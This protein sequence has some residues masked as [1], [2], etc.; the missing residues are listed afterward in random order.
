MGIG[1]QDR[2][3]IFGSFFCLVCILHAPA[4][5]AESVES[6]EQLVITGSKL[7]RIITETSESMT[8]IT[9]DDIKRYQYRN[10]SEAL[11]SVPGIH[12]STS[13][14]MG[15]QTSVFIRGSESDHVLV[16]IDGIKV[17]DPASGGVFEFS[18]L[19]L[20]NVERIE[21]V[22]GGHGAHYGSEALGGVIHVITRRSQPAAHLLLERGSFNSR[23]A[24]FSFGK[25]GA[26]DFSL[27]ASYLKTDGESFTP[28]RLREG[29]RE[30]NDGYRNA[31]INVNVGWFIKDALQVDFHSGYTESETEYDSS[32]MPFENRLLEDSA[33]TKR[34]GVAISG[35]Y[36]NSFWQPSWRLNRY[37]RKH[38][39]GSERT[40]GERT[41][42]SWSNV[43]HFD[44]RLSVVIGAESE[45]ER[46][47]IANVLGAKARTR[48]VYGE[49]NLAPV[50][51]VHLSYGWRNDDAD[52]FS[53]KRTSHVGAVW[54]AND[55]LILRADYA[56]AFK[57]PTLSDRF[58]DFPL[59]NFFANPNLE[60]E[61]NRHWQIGFEQLLQDWYFGATYFNNRIRNL[62]MD[63]YEQGRGTL[64]NQNGARIEGLE[65]FVSW[66]PSDTWSMRLDY[67][68]MSPYG[69]DHERLLRR[70]GR[71]LSFKMDALLWSD[72]DFSLRLEHIGHRSDL[73][74]VTLLPKTVGGYSLAYLNVRKKI[75]RDIDLFAGVNNLFDKR[76]EPVDGF[77]GRGI[78]FN[79][80]IAVDF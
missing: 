38:D 13:G 66:H 4:V 57:A 15:A 58:R 36:F 68:L 60:P 32:F 16:M 31:A 42:V 64:V 50:D 65:S 27:G 24:S 11:S 12:I 75:S 71:K 52:D 7:P 79:A 70:P 3:V 80:G 63:V 8:I 56:T 22:R 34:S 78:E 37:V 76:Y 49:L 72:I 54:Q 46:L 26:V 30:E 33:Y 6:L 41:D 25:E 59:F 40:R 2:F 35:D 51:N 61:T 48:S 1:L 77:A 45:L 19:P 10:L 74:R 20:L 53:S 39:G 21:I 73:D 29:Q 23:R 17:S 43:L 18:Y 28:R 9:A 14:G 67:S 55:D 69:D 5:L 44:K 47:R 62:I